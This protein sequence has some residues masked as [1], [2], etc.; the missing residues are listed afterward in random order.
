[1]TILIKKIGC[2]YYLES[3]RFTNIEFVGVE[4]GKYYYKVY[5]PYKDK[6]ALIEFVSDNN[7]AL[8]VRIKYDSSQD[9]ELFEK[10]DEDVKK[11]T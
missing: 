11:S 5:C 6:K 1:M 9:F 2:E 3:S 8:L 10:L 4:N 7:T